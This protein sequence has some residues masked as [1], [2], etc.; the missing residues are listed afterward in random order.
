MLFAGEWKLYRGMQ[1]FK[2]AM[3]E[4]EKQVLNDIQ[5]DYRLPVLP[6]AGN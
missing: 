4:K 3:Q 5:R 2:A 6:R 1:H